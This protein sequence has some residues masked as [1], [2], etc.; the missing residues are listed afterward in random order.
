MYYKVENAIVNMHT[1]LNED[2]DNSEEGMNQYF[3]S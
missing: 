2:V 3:I 1:V